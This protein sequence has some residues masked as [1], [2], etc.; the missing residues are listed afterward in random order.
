MKNE[1]APL[2]HPNPA[3][4]RHTKTLSNKTGRRL[5]PR[6]YPHQREASVLWLPGDP[7]WRRQIG[8]AE[9]EAEGGRGGQ[10]GRNRGTER[11][12]E[13]LLDWVPLEAGVRPLNNLWPAYAAF[14]RPKNVGHVAAGLGLELGSLTKIWEVRRDVVWDI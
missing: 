10:G 11:G 5:E 13:G 2:T 8:E 3:P 14:P 1:N 12:G 9:T 7:R 4:N 6:S